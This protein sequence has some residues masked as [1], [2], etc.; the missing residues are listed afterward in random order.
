MVEFVGRLPFHQDYP[1]FHFDH[2]VWVV[3][4][5][6]SPLGAG[7]LDSPVLDLHLD[8]IGQGNGFP[9]DAGEG[10]FLFSLVHSR[11]TR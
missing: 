4:L 10:F 8:A 9:A 3:F 5:L 11:I 6:K 2:H 7:D 1:V